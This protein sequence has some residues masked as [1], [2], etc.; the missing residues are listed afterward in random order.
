M[1]YCELSRVKLLVT[2]I[3]Q[4]VDSAGGNDTEM[5]WIQHKEVLVKALDSSIGLRISA[6]QSAVLHIY[7]KEVTIEYLRNKS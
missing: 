7:R 3:V 5:L 6:V 2:A 1:F 4:V